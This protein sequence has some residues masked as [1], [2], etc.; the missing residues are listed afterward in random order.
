VFVSLGVAGQWRTILQ[1]AYGTSFGIAD[2]VFGRDAGYYVFSLPAID[3]VTSVLYGILLLSLFLVA[4]PLHLFRGEVARSPRGLSIGPRGQR[5]LG[6]L[7]AALLVLT[8]VR[9]NLVRIPGLVFAEHASLSGANYVDLHTRV[10]ALHVMTVV[11]V[12]GA[13]LLAWGSLRGRLVPVGTRVAIGYVAV[14]LLAAVIPA[15]YQR[16]VVQPNEL[17]RETP[18][19]VHHIKAT[20]QAW[21]LDDIEGRGRHGLSGRE[22]QRQGRGG[23]RAGQPTHARALR[24]IRIHGES[25]GQPAGRHENSTERNTRSGC[26]MR[27]VKRPSGVVTEVMPCGDPFGL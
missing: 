1:A 25:S 16:L 4:L 20:R 14:A 8:A 24:N 17:A 10:P 3:L 7:A 15:I 26:G 9:T 13:A 22:A 5:H 27:I 18:Q 11:A 12:L 6:L 23:P 2:P 19:I 21:G